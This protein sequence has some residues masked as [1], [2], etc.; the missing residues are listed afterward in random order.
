MLQQ[1]PYAEKAK[2]LQEIDTLKAEVTYL[3]EII[4]PKE[5][6][7][8]QGIKLTRLQ[9]RL[10]HALETAPDGMRSRT[11]IYHR[12]YGDEGPEPKILDVFVSTIRKLLPPEIKIE[13]LWGRGWA[14][15]KEGRASLSRRRAPSVENRGTGPQ[16][17]ARY[18]QDYGDRLLLANIP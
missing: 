12:L 10:V 3:R 11:A 18:N 13:T 14:I 5:D 9:A 16:P 8:Y 7:I 15:N 17:H 4:H 1:S 2:M 6:P